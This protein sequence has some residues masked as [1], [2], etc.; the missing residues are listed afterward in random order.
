MS[1]KIL[2][3]YASITGSTQEIAEEVGNVLRKSGAEVEV[4]PVKDVKDVRAYDA[5]VLGS[6][7]RGAKVLPDA[8][9]FV[10]RNKAALSKLPTAYFTV[11]LT[12]KDD[13]PENR[14]IVQAYSKPLRDLLLPVTE[15]WFAG[16]M[17]YSKLGKLLRWMFKH[18]KDSPPEGDFRDW[19]AIRAWAGELSTKLHL[20]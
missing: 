20:A 5:V 3:A 9:Q 11:C 12:L 17:D 7:A 14:T 1:E 15:G 4:C 2:V 18:S 16:A 8:V 10:Q 6:A 13:T 19:T